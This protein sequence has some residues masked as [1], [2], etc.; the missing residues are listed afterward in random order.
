MSDPQSPASPTPPVPPSAPGAGVPPAPVEGDAS[1]SIAPTPH[2]SQGYWRLVWLQFRKNGAAFKSLVL[3][4]MLF[5]IAAFAPVLASG[6]PFVWTKDGVTKY[7]LFQ[8]LVAPQS[9]ITIDYFF[10]YLFFATLTVTFCL[11]LR[12]IAWKSLSVRRATLAGLALAVLPFIAPPWQWKLDLAKRDVRIMRSWR[13][14]EVDYTKLAKDLDRSKGDYAL[15]AL[16]AADPITPKEGMILKKPSG[17]FLLGSDKDGRD[18]LARMLHGARISISVGFVAVLIEVVLG[19]FF[20][21]LAGYFRGWV[22]VLISRFIELVICFPSFFLILTIVAFI[23][24]EKRSVF[25]IMLI[26][27][28]TG[29]TG[30]ARLVRGE[31]LKLSEQDFVHAARAL[32]CSSGRLMFR[33]I[34]PNAMAPVL[35]AAAFGIA[36]AILTESSLSFLGF[37]APPPTPTWGE[38]ISQGKEHVDTAWWLIVFPGAAIFLTVTVYNL[39]GDGLRDAMDPKMRK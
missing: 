11:L 4:V 22:D 35:V 3:I 37:G 33:H 13:N 29:W 6:K 15:F 24:P 26:I 38:M 30:V 27:G 34:L 21:A 14:D 25:H 7:P 32:G 12:R 20:G 5:M 28:I 36:G 8:Y 18:V 23:E 39:A 19:I 17:E 1:N 10:N 2:R 16:I 9:T 31:F